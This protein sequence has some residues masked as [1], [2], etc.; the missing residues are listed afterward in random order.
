VGPNASKPGTALC[1]WQFANLPQFGLEPR[2][3]HQALSLLVMG[4]V[5]FKTLGEEMSGSRF[6]FHLGILFLVSLSVSAQAPHDGVI[7][8]SGGKDTVLMKPWSTTITPAEPVSPELFTIDSNLG[9]GNKVYNAGAGNGIVG[10][11]AGQLYS[12]RMGNAFQAK[13]EHVVTVIQVAGTFVS[14]GNAVVLS[15]N[16]DANN[17]PGPALYTRH[18]AN[19]PQFGSCCKLLT[20]FI[21][22]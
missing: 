7:T 2:R 10:P 3:W 14:G 11:D 21:G 9:T 20:T 5:R 22:S 1:T 16:G 15:L 18:F 6:F 17:R 19:L 4:H 12:E 8:I 13:A